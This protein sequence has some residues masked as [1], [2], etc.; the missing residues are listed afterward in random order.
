[1]DLSSENNIDRSHF[2]AVKRQ[3]TSYTSPPSGNSVSTA[4]VF[5]DGGAHKPS[6]PLRSTTELPPV[7]ASGKRTK[8]VNGR[9][10]FIADLEEAAAT[11]DDGLEFQGF[12]MKDTSEYPNSHYF[13]CFAQDEEVPT[14]ILNV[15]DTI[16][17]QGA[18]PID[19]ILKTILTLLAKKVA[20]NGKGVYDSDVEVD[21]EDYEDL[22]VDMSDDEHYDEHLGIAN[23]G[24]D[25]QSKLQSSFLTRDFVEIVAAEYHP[26]VVRF[27][28][29]DRIIS[30][31]I[32]AFSLAD[33]IDPRALMAWDPRLLSTTRH[34]TLLITGLRGVYPVIQGDGKLKHQF[35][36][37]GAKPRF[38]IGLSKDYKPS[39]EQVMELIRS[40][41]HHDKPA[42]VQQRRPATPIFDSSD[43]EDEYDAPD[44]HAA[45][46]TAEP[47]MQL[48]ETAPEED[49]DFIPFSLSSSLEPLLNDRF[50]DILLCRVKYNL[51]WA[52][53]EVLVNEIHRLQK[54]A[55]TALQDSG[56]SQ[57]VQY[58][59][60]EEEGLLASYRLPD[61]PL[62][63]PDRMADHIN[64]PLVAFS[65][66]LR[67]LALCSRFCLVCYD[68]VQ[69]EVLK[70]YVCENKLCTY[71]YYNLNRG[72]SLEYE[73][74][75]RPQTV[76]LLVS[77][78]YV[79][80]MEGTLDDFPDG[81]NL[82]VPL[83]WDPEGGLI[84]FDPLPHQHKQ[85]VVASLLAFLPSVEDMKRYLESKHGR[86]INP[87][88]RACD[89]NVPAAAWSVLRWCI[90]SCTAHLEELTAEEDRVGNVGSEWTQFRFTVGAPNAEAQ[91]AAEQEKAR[92]K[93]GN[94]RIYPSL[95]A[96]HGSPVKNWHSIIRHGLW[97]KTI[98]HGRA[99]GDGVYFA[100]DG[101]VSMTGYTGMT[102]TSWPKTA[103]YISSCVALAEIV[104]L[105]N[106]FRS[107]TPFFVVPQTHW[108]VCRYLLVKTLPLID[109]PPN[110]RQPVQVPQVTLDP[111]HPLTIGPKSITIPNP[112]YLLSLVLQQ[113]QTEY[114]EHTYDEDDQ[115]VL[116][117]Q[118]TAIAAP[119]P[120]APPAEPDW[121][122]D[123]EWVRS[124][125]GHIF[126]APTDAMHSA[127]ATLQRELATLLKEQEKARNLRELGWYMPPDFIT[128][129]LFQWIVELHSFEKNLPI[130]Q[131][132]EFRKVNSLVFEIRFPYN[133]P[134]SPPFFRI[135]KPRFLPFIH[136]GGGHVTGGGSM[137]MDL[138]TADGWLPS[139]SI[140]AVL[141]QIKLAI[142]NLDP[143]PARLA[144]N[145]DHPYTIPEALEGYKRAART[146]GWRIPTTLD[147]L[148]T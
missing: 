133:Y 6:S 97:Y 22:D 134:L 102:V 98:A 82:S 87:M 25:N 78:T 24:R 75:T 16:A 60:S 8:P 59:D 37:S 26:G 54:D 34:L 115:T 57:K 28:V 118:N 101:N 137:C 73:I 136:G 88:L 109:P 129:N 95:Y 125:V 70:P 93:D 148:F 51:G 11:C 142:S 67:R 120:Y 83:P 121:E 62:N 147:R 77:L 36:A 100:K 42:P 40:Y 106:E 65:Y 128:D 56:V 18:R 17:D 143:R 131:D 44:F 12:R 74:C 38:K 94:A 135:L 107:T 104:N 84:D 91:F 112:A 64:L 146:H 139:Y 5:E 130:A 53:A 113:R 41:S 46:R 127:T 69:T 117:A 140:S 80:A 99:Y 21:E 47:E 29:N 63:A 103:L 111:K 2:P 76:D 33:T 145:W 15:I 49:R 45:Y 92:A 96:F 4:F 85:Q 58:A 7:M 110:Q 89:P 23:T 13:I 30:V 32:P 48:D 126:A 138:L 10:R 66:L 141:L 39:K 79:A 68:R 124:C 27:G 114:M 20:A 71:Q 43:E 61:D 81:M 31:S 132:L 116:C 3:R 86:G 90:A 119:P 1:M 50:F 9:R 55:D 123:P 72:P 144:Q 108:I 105:P 35:A 52:G 19:D 14:Y 122:H